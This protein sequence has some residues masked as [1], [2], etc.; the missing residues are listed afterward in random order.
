MLF[1]AYQTAGNESASQKAELDSDRAV[2]MQA[3]KAPVQ[4]EY[5]VQLSAPSYR[6]LDYPNC[7]TGRGTT[8]TDTKNDPW[9]Q[10]AHCDLI[11]FCC[12]NI[13]KQY[14]QCAISSL[15]EGPLLELLTISDKHRA[16][17][18]KGCNPTKII[19]YVL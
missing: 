11:A 13:C 19:L 5:K 2:N 9:A 14:L 12:F 18:W 10:P 3:N 1:S 17:I 8:R 16:N 15:E 7:K 6:A 4:I